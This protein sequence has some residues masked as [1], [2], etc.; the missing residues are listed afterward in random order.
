MWSRQQVSKSQLRRPPDL[1]DPNQD[2]NTQLDTACKLSRSR[3]TLRLAHN[4]SAPGR[5]PRT[6]NQLGSPYTMR[7][8]PPSKSHLDT[9][10]APPRKEG[11]KNQ[12]D[13]ACT[14]WH[15]ALSRSQACTAPAHRCVSHRM[16]LRDR[17][18]SLPALH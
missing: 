15:A 17:G 18:R 10:G 13:T 7:R 5:Q 6:A 12:L 4:Q 3:T 14:Q 11:S 8:H 1:L 9:V 2:T 16:T